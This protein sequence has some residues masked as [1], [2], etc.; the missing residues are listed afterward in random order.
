MSQQNQEGPQ[1]ITAQITATTADT[2][3]LKVSSKKRKEE[4]KQTLYLKRI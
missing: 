4:A 1:E 3:N 2:G